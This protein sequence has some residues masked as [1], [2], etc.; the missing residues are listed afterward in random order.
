MVGNRNFLST[1][2]NL[3]QVFFSAIL[4]SVQFTSVS[5]FEGGVLTEI[6]AGWYLLL[7]FRICIVV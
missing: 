5:G 4:L 1:K 6:I 2:V 3:N 7:S